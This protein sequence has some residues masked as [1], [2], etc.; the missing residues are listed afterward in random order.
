M[1]VGHESAV[2]APH[3]SQI[4]STSWP[5]PYS[6]HDYPTFYSTPMPVSPESLQSYMPHTSKSPIPLQDMS[7]LPTSGW[8]GAATS[9]TEC[10]IESGYNLY[11]QYI[12]PHTSSIT[13]SPP[14]PTSSY[15][16]KLS[17]PLAR[18]NSSLAAFSPASV[19]S[20]D[21]VVPESRRPSEEPQSDP[22]C[23]REKSSTSLN[24]GSHPIDRPHSSPNLLQP[25]PVAASW[26]SSPFGIHTPTM[27]HDSYYPTFPSL[28]R[29]PRLSEPLL[30]LPSNHLASP[31]PRRLWTPI[32]PQPM[33]APRS[34]TIKRHR[35]EDGEVVDESKRKKRSDST[36]SQ[37]LELSEEDKLLLQLK[38]EDGMPW[39]DIAARF[40]SELGKTYQIPALQMRLKR[41]R[42]R[43][44]VWTEVDVEALRMATEYWAQHKFEII[45]QKMLEF[46]AQ[47]KWTPRQCVRKWM[48]IDPSPDTYDHYKP[49]L[50]HGY[51]PSPAEHPPSFLPY[52]H[53]Q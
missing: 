7:T 17:V 46:G 34:S 25:V 43:M 18:M 23:M 41:L 24:I 28:I 4:R 14:T 36:G 37:Q 16:G 44:R 48:E 2:P 33:E 5:S 29:N 31:Q 11:D 27:Q 21:S 12:P 9:A 40:Q 6:P 47:E 42:E 35:E 30:E 51:T 50:H 13:L 1:S 38:E 20:R 26:T 8:Y 49:Q 45:A 32:A 53:L 22:N 19:Y 39:K 10:H 15:V 3:L 52:M